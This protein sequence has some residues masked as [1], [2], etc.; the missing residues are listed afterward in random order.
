MS[1]A[2]TPDEELVF[3]AD[4]IDEFVQRGRWQQIMEARQEARDALREAPMQ[5]ASLRQRMSHTEAGEAVRQTV[6]AA[7]ESYVMEVERLYHETEPGRKLWADTPL[8]TVNCRQLFAFEGGEHDLEMESVHFSGGLGPRGDP[9]QQVQITG[10]RDWLS[11]SDVTAR[12]K[13]SGVVRVGSQYRSKEREGESMV[14]TPVS[15]SKEVYRATNALVER[16]GPGM[17]IGATDSGTVDGSYAELLE[18]FD[19]ET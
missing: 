11:L 3:V 16:L 4:S 15:V 18:E 2:P 7:V 19:D 12:Y 6:H 17:D 8:A 13:L 9:N 5:R 14:T 10:V 1:E